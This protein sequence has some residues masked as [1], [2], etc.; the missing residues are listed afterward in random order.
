MDSLYDMD[1]YW[2]RCQ[3]FFWQQNPYNLWRIYNDEENIKRSIQQFTSGEGNV[4]ENEYWTAKYAHDSAFHPVTGSKVNMLGRMG[5]QVFL[6]PMS[7][8]VNEPNKGARKL[9]SHWMHDHI[10]QEPCR[11][12]RPPSRQSNVQLKRQLLQLFGR[13]VRGDVIQAKV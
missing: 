3:H 10:L 1:T 12:C 8:H 7:T 4:T 9:H 11:R 13:C 5:F 6:V 2:G